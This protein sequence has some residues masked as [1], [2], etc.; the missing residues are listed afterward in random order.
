MEGVVDDD[1]TVALI[2]VQLAYTPP[3]SPPRVIYLQRAH[4][5]NGKYSE[6]V[7]K[8][9]FRWYRMKPYLTYDEYLHLHHITGLTVT[10]IN[11]WFGNAR[12]RKY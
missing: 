11:T 1:D 9:L 6:R 7:Y 5:K 12:R 2:L 8:V 4:H 3:P 10:Q